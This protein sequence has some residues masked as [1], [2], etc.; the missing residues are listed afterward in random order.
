MQKKEDSPGISIIVAVYNAEQYLPVC[1]DSILK[2]T[3]VNYEILLVDDGSMDHS[4]EICDEYALKDSRIRVFHK[5]NGGVSSAR[6]TGILH[7]HG[8]YSIHIDSDDWIEPR[9]LEKLWSKAEAEKA[10]MVIADFFEHTNQKVV[11]KTQCPEILDSRNVIRE[12]FVGKL[13]GSMWNKLVKQDLYGKYG[14]V[15]PEGIN[16]CEDVMVITQFLLHHPKVVYLP[17]A[18]YHYMYNPSSIIRK[19]TRRTFNELFRFVE[20]MQKLLRTDAYLLE[21]LNYTKLTIRKDALFCGLYTRQEYD[22]IYKET[23]VLIWSA[24][25][26]LPVKILLFIA[27]RRGYRVVGCVVYLRNLLR[28]F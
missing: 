22:N 19:L 18:F 4:G 2:Q 3:Y 6:N 8:K 20:E 23:D 7:A 26:R 5:E 9:M 16:C 11:M 27:A 12:I 28:C 13:H 25:F 21:Y 17:E 15:F 14:I 1:M 10:D 24:Y